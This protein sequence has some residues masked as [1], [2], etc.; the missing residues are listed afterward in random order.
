MPEQR[1]RKQRRRLGRCGM[2]AVVACGVGGMLHVQQEGTVL[3]KLTIVRMIYH[4]H[5]AGTILPYSRSFSLQL[6]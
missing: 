3:E 4:F 6:H 5:A 2:H 1:R